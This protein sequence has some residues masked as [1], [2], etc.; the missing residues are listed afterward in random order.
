MC[1]C[2]CITLVNYYVLLLQTSFTLPL[3]YRHN[4]TLSC[5]R[6]SLGYSKQL[7]LTA[8][9]VTVVCGCC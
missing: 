2:V 8:Q 5:T 7:P 4:T 9:N 6:S 3:L 1:V